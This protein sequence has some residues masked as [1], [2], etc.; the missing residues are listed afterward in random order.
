MSVI[1]FITEAFLIYN[2]A[3]LNLVPDYKCIDVN[4]VARSCPQSDT[5]LPQFNRDLSQFGEHDQ[6]SGYLTDG[7]SQLVLRNWMQDLDL[8]CAQKWEIGLFGSLFFIGN[9]FGSIF[10]SN[11]GDTVGRI[12]LMK[13]SQFITFIC[14]S[15]IVYYIRSIQTI[16]SLIFIVG[17]LQPWRL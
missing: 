16:Y 15:S 8:R 1:F 10:L 17:L 14:Y 13:V 5:C 6:V 4:R 11:F 9:L 12:P 2:L 7:T 3:F